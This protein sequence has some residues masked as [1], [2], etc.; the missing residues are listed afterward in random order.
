MEHF[1]NNIDG[2][3]D[4]QDVYDM[5]IEKMQDGSNI[6]EVGVWKGKSIS[7]LG[8]LIKNSNKK[9]KAYAVDTWGK[10][11]TENYHADSYFKDD[12][13]YKNFI[14][15]IEP[16]SDVIIPCRGTSLEICKTF[17]DKYF[18]IVFIDACHDYECIKNDIQN[19]LPKV[20][21]KG[22]IGGHDIGFP[23][24][25]RAVKEYFKENQINMKANSWWVY[26]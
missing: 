7:Y 9:I 5:F 11:E 19:W 10:L 14:Q 12:N 18:D 22:I 8:V 3:F 24:V 15:T 20:K 26:L 2:W 17:P 16:I 6:A 23:G 1:Y 13:L 25:S 21:T 4:F